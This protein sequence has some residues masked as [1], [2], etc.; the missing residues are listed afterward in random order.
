MVSIRHGGRAFR[1]G[2]RC[3]ERLHLAVPDSIGEVEHKADRQPDEQ[4][5][6]VRPTEAIDHRT[7]DYDSCGRNE[8]DGGHLKGALKVWA[9][10]PQD[11]DSDTYKNEG[12]Q[13]A[14]T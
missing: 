12:K 3:I 13:R 7:A 1:R 8:R 11:P 9:F 10:A 2:R 14:D 4:T 5:Q 6:P